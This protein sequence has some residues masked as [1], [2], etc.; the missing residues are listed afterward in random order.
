MQKRKTTKKTYKKK[1]VAKRTAF[2]WRS[3]VF[4]T[5]AVGLGASTTTVL[6]TSFFANVTAAAGTGIFTGFLKPGS[7]FDPSGDISTIQP[8]L[9]DQFAAVYQRYK[10]DKCRVHMN[11]TGATSG[12]GA[13]SWVCAAYPSIDSTALATYQAAASQ[14]W[15]KTTSGGFQLAS[16]ATSY[17]VGAEPKMIKH[18]FTTNAV[19]GTKADP[20]DNGALVTADPTVNQYIVYPFLLQANAAAASTWVIEVDMWQTVTFSQRKNVTDA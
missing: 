13:Y 17:G 4:A 19:V 20:Y 15:A 11:I 16:G 5:P 7:C 3:N 18:V 1:A 14:P 6:R 12:T 10:V 2:P 9:F 8:A